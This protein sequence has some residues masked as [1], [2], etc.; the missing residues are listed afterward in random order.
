MDSTI[1]DENEIE[2]AWQSCSKGEVSKVQLFLK[3]SPTLLDFKYEKWNKSTLLYTAARNGQTK[4]VY[5]LLNRGG[6]II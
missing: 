5:I 1:V 6:I 2:V 3:K 4:I